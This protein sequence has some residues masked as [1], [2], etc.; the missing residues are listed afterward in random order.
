M[1]TAN[2]IEILNMAIG[3]TVKSVVL[4][5][6]FSG[7]IRKRNLKRL[8]KMKIDEKD[9]EILFL[10]DTVDQLKMQI[11]ILQKGVKKKATNNRYTFGEKL[12]ILHYVETFQI[13]RHRIG[14]SLGI[15]RS[16]YYRWLRS[17]EEKSRKVSPAN[18]TPTEIA[19]LV[20]EIARANA[21]WGRIRIANQ[22]ALLKIFIA[23]STVRNI[24]DRPEPRNRPKAKVKPD[25]NKPRTIPARY[26]NHV[27]SIDMTMVYRWGLWP[28]HI[29]VAIDHFSR[30]VVAT[31]PLE[32]PNA[33]WT[34]NALESAIEK[35]G[36]PKHLISDQGSVFTG[37]VFAELL[38][39]YKIKHRL[40]AVGKHGSIAV[41]ERVNKTLKYEWLRR[42][43]I[44]K[45]IDHLAELCDE[46]Q[47]WYNH[48]RPHMT[49][50]GLRPD[51]VY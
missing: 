40:G 23:G 27:W 48:W 2:R 16:T 9:K 18:K 37:E 5:A 7:R 21:D 50:D 3:L 11:S 4:A 29:C 46:F 25:K 28:I 1:Q 34:V 42:V 43:A 41:T 49:L 45:G 39:K 51:D 12:Y 14:E 10:R 44:I 33:G 47:L 17:I 26:P 15:A 19:A 13:A 6:Q 32:G 31:A 35:Y 30:K 20:W 8:S 38:N 36:P 22:L 24:L